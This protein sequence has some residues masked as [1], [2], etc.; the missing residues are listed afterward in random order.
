MEITNKDISHLLRSVAAVYLLTNENRFKVIAYE[1]AVDAVDRLN[2]E[3]KDIW[4]NNDLSRV[5]GIGP[6]ILSHIDDYFKNGDSSY[7]KRITKK[8]PPAVFELIK[9]PGIGP[10]KAFK[11]VKKLKLNKANS[12]VEDLKLACQTD[13]ISH[14]ESFGEKSQE[15]I[16]SAV[17]IYQKRSYKQ[18][19]MVLP[20]AYSL[21]EEIINY[22]KKNS[23]IQKA[24]VLGSLRRMTA[25]IGDID[26]VIVC[27][28]Q[29]AK[30]AIEY[31]VSYPS[32]VSI[33]EKGEKKASIIATGGR[34][35]DLRVIDKK[36]YGS[37]L[38]YFTGSKEHNIKLREYA[39]KKDFS[40]S[41]YGIKD[42]KK[43]F[44]KK[45]ETEEDFYQYLNL[46]YIPPELR[47]GT[48]E[49]E[50]ARQQKLPSLVDLKDIRGDFHIHSS[51]NLEPSHDLGNN[52][53]EELLKKTEQLNYEYIAFSDHNPSISNH[54]DKDIVNILRQRHNAIQNIMSKKNE[55]PNYF[56]SLEVDILTNGKIALPEKALAYLDMIIVAVHNS[57]RMTKEDMT[58]RILTALKFP[59][60]KI[61][62]HPT[63]R[64]LGKRE[65]I[66]ADWKQIFETCKKQNIALEINAWPDRLDLPD[67]LVKQA[68]GYGSK[69]AINSDAHDIAEMDNMFY[70]V[71]VARRG[72]AKKS[73]IINTNNYRQIKKW[74]ENE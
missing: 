67:T 27:K 23:L 44:V 70:G 1:K 11:L 69:L 35:I 14:I 58:K 73:D 22:L 20:Y 39:L 10:K 50:I 49:I 46:Q 63:C 3:L 16:L 28:N 12:A 25:T 66:D 64:L 71:S 53:F 15:E 6:S 31:F 45:I 32:R 72:W 30:E 34:K 26:I 68:I 13:K 5:E 21:A 2:R 24:Q 47:E 55:R 61:L 51:Y 19:R 8:L 48:N 7:L 57:F 36:E 42:I 4:Q 43:S 38:Q 74:I 60:V 52:T 54:Q 17:E 62:A 29:H 59:K 56:I 65:E 18:E 33:E 37:M 41:E 40:L 9:I